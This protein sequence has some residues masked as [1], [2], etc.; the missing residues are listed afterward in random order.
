MP[1]TAFPHIENYLYE[2]NCCIMKAGAFRE[3][4]NEYN[5]LSK[6]HNNTHLF[7]SHNKIEGFPG[8]IF[9]IEDIVPYKDKELKKIAYK[10]PHINVSV[11]NMPITAEQLKTKLKVRDG[12]EKYLFGVTLCNGSKALLIC[13][14]V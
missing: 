7:V 11:R 12:G 1:P 4:A 6:L 13:K 10:Y 14:K 2:P 5:D 8:R 3:I 9:I